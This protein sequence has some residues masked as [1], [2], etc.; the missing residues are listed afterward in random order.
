MTTRERVNAAINH[1][2]PDRVP[3]DLGLT[4]VTG[5]HASTL[6]YLRKPLGL[7]DLTVK[8]HEVFQQLGFV[9]EGVRQAL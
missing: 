2:Q 1:K 4:A 9:D 3:I 6:Y 8:V 5:I 7:K